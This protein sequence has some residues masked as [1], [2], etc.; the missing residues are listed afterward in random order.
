MQLPL[1]KNLD[2][3]A[4]K[5]KS[6][7]DPVLSNPLTN[8]T[9]LERVVLASGNNQIA[10]KLGRGQQGWIITDI[11]AAVT[12]FRYQAFNDTYLY[13]TASGAAIVNLGVF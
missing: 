9:V 8:M 11:N 10:H 1:F 12:I 3:L 5:W 4:T 6:I 13:L 7:L 2:L